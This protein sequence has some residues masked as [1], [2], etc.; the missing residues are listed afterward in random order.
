MAKEEPRAE[1]LVECDKLNGMIRDGHT[2]VQEQLDFLVARRSYLT[3]EQKEAVM[4]HA[5]TH[6]LK[7]PNLLK[8]EAPAEEKK[9]EK[10]KK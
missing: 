4:E 9:D 7:C 6:D 2:L 3:D 1:F 10:K 5:K 8:E